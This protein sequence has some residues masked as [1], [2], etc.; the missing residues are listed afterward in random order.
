MKTIKGVVDFV[1]SGQGLL[2]SLKESFNSDKKKGWYLV[3]RGLDSLIQQGKFVEFEELIRNGPYQHDPIFQCGVYLRI[4]SIARNDQLN[5]HTRK[6]AVLLLKDLYS[7]I[8]DKTDYDQNK[9][10]ILRIFKLLA[11]SSDVLIAG[12]T[13]E[14]LIELNINID[15]IPQDATLEYLRS[16]L[17]NLPPSGSILLGRAQNRSL[18]ELKIE[19]LQ[20]THLQDQTGG[21]YISPMGKTTINSKDSF[22]LKTKVDEFLD[23]DKKVLLILGNSG[24]GKSTF[25]NAIEADL[26]KKY[27]PGDDIPLFINLPS[28]TNP[29][30]DM[31]S[32]Q[33]HKLNI[34]T[35]DEIRELMKNRKFILI[36]DAYDETQLR[37]NLYT[38]NQLNEAGSWKVQM[39]IS[40]RI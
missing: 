2:E 23:S 39:I 21:V 6:M 38:S 18:T 22:D 17:S 5:D 13:K 8:A 33:L 37:S 30:D 24:A 14:C 26:W 20:E 10:W 1:E 27:Q 40:C 11:N 7:N 36:C 35:D 34:F 29:E 3:L 4:E 12:S 16:N 31:V 28:I 15:S 25:N 32:K 19:E 9:Q